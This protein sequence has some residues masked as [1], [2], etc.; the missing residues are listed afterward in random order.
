MQ[1]EPSLK[2]VLLA[3]LLPRVGANP[4]SEKAVLA[5]VAHVIEILPDPPADV[6]PVAHLVGEVA[7]ALHDSYGHTNAV[8]DAYM[9]MLDV[10]NRIEPGNICDDEGDPDYDFTEDDLWWVVGEI[11][12]CPAPQTPP[13]RET[14]RL[15]TSMSMRS[16]IDWGDR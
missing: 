7:I 10:I 15:R 6:R 8:H 9:Q 11:L 13:R 12:R 5:L 14:G 1:R 2:P 16:T 3:W 4:P